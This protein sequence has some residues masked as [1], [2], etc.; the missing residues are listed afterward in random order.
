MDRIK[1]LC[2]YL[3][4]CKSFADVGCDHGYCTLYMLKNNLCESAQI[5]DISAKC[6]E[7]AENLLAPYMISG[8]VKSVCCSGLKDINKDTEQILIAGMGGEEI[9]LILKAAFI[10]EKFV[11]QPM[12]NARLL[13]EYLIENGADI[14]VDEIFESGGKFYTVIKGKRCG[15]KTEYTLTELKYG[16]ALQSEA[17]K[18]FLKSELAKKERYLENPVNEAARKTITEEI[19]TIKE[20][21]SGD[22]R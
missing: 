2:S 1:K 18:R 19:N 5:S 8:K 7:K 20:V 22:N 4:C 12:K 6:L 21:L 13:R 10:P 17:T 14:T 3:D 15:K 16:K 11:L 9:I